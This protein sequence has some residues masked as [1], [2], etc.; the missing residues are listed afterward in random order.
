MPALFFTTALSRCLFNTKKFQH[1]ATYL[2][3]DCGAVCVGVCGPHTYYKDI[4]DVV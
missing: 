1:F 3:A 2:R 4:K